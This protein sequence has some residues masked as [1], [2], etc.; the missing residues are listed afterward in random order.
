MDR[1]AAAFEGGIIGAKTHRI[2]GGGGGA[3][4]VL[5]R[6]GGAEIKIETSP[7]MRGVVHDSEMRPVSDAVEDE[8]G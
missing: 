8:F 6:L 3:T 1:I 4:R 7:V 5:A 2:Q